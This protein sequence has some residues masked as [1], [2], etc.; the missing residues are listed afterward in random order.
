MVAT[1]STCSTIEKSVCVY[2]CERE[3]EGE[4]ERKDESKRERKTWES[5]E[6]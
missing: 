5:S 4:R 1:T 6:T 2:V 3:K